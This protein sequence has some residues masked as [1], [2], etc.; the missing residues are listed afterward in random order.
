MSIERKVADSGLWHTIWAWVENRTLSKGDKALSVSYT[1]KFNLNTSPHNAVST[2][3]KR[4]ASPLGS[5]AVEHTWLFT[6]APSHLLLSS[7][8][9]DALA[10]LLCMTAY[11]SPPFRPHW[12]QSSLALAL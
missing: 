1:L 9:M 6:P 4:A 10:S 8:G 5:P 3:A 7:P 12:L 2:K 11:P